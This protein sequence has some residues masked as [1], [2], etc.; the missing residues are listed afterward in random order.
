MFG[1]KYCIKVHWKQKRKDKEGFLVY[2]THTPD[3]SPVFLDVS[4]FIQKI[5]FMEGTIYMDR[6]MLRDGIIA[7]TDENGNEKRLLVLKRKDIHVVLKNHAYFTSGHLRAKGIEVKSYDVYRFV[8]D[9]SA[10]CDMG[11]KFL[12]NIS[13]EDAIVL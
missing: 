5:D 6:E 11:T 7:V 13:I 9:S 4:D 3:T 8:F 1:R 10:S 2:S 12:K